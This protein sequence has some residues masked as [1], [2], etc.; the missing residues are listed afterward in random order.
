MAENG[1]NWPCLCEPDAGWNH[2]MALE[3]GISKVPSSFLIN[4]QGKVIAV[5]LRNDALRKSLAE[6]F[7]NL[8]ED[9]SPRNN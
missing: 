1:V 2:P 6:I 9:P 7:A 8:P 4:P 5:N 3:Y